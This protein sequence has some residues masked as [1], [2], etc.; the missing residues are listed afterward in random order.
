MYKQ[1]PNAYTDQDSKSETAKKKKNSLETQWTIPPYAKTSSQINNET[2]TVFRS[3]NLE[4]L[5]DDSPI[6]KTRQEKTIQSRRKKTK[7]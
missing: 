1:K 7:P 2:V 5:I 6:A 4:T 3:E